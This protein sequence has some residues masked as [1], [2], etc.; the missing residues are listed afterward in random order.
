MATK[1]QILDMSP[2]GMKFTVLQ[3]SAD[4]DGKSLDL[5][6]ELMPGC[7]MKDPLVHTHPHA[8]ET[9]EILDG[10]MEFFVK[11]KW[12]K[13]KKGDKISVD[14]GIAHTFRNPTD[15]PVYVFNT[16][17]P[18]LKMENYFEDVCKV[19][20]KVTD[21]GKKE[22]KMNL[23]GKMYLSLLMT[24]YPDEITAVKPPD[25]VIKVMGRIARLLNFR[26]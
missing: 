23:R 1:N 3:T 11:D 17:Q 13:A 2:L 5:H 16:H 20:D 24:N 7:N 15:K 8:M 19:L 22:L 25:A 14:A 21:K 9:Y 12:V 6:W 10:E 4:T 26:Y 18:A